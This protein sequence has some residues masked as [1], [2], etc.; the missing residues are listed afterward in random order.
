MKRAQH[1]R[2]HTESADLLELLLDEMPSGLDGILF[3]VLVGAECGNRKQV[4][5]WC[6]D[7]MRNDTFSG[8]RGGNQAASTSTEAAEL[9]NLAKHS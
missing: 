1:T 2:R 4:I 9:A 5:G 6:T 8:A 7:A 3:A